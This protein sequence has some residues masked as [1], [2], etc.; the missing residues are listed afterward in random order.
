M[1]M[2]PLASLQESVQCP[3]QK[4]LPFSGAD[5]LT[6]PLVWSPPLQF[7]T[8]LFLKQMLV[9]Y[10]NNSPPTNDDQWKNNGVTKT[11]DRLM[12]QVRCVALG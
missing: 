6:L 12:L 5:V 8:N 2:V 9:R 4:T 10:Q 11:W 1:S 7:T 3:L